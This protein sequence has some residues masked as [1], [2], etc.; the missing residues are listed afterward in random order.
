RRGRKK[1]KKQQKAQKQQNQM[2][3]R[4]GFHVP[5]ANERRF[6]PNEVLLNISTAASLRAVDAIALKYRL[7]RLDVQDFVLTR[8]R[9][10]RLRINDGRSVAV[11]IRALQSDARVLGAQP[12]YLY[13]MQQSAAAPVAADP[14]QYSLAK[15]HLVEA[16]ALAKGDRILVAV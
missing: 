13:A 3:Q 2:A 15:L 10:A 14:A 9:L 7:T 5:P 1:T 12:N 16:H 8:H 6:V 11:V 4:G